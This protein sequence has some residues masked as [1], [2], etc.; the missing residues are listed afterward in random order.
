METLLDER[1]Q[2][3]DKLC[4]IVTVKQ[5]DVV[6][7]SENFGQETVEELAKTDDDIKQVMTKVDGLAASHMKSEQEFLSK[8]LQ[9]T[10]QKMDKQSSTLQKHLT[11]TLSVAQEQ[12]T[13]L[14]RQQSS[15]DSMIDAFKKHVSCWLLVSF[16]QLL[17]GNVQELIAIKDQKPKHCQNRMWN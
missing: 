15:M 4:N 2:T 9:G 17:G 8:M 16:F 1:G 5:N 7:M 10:K 3:Q 6:K 13:S 12:E 11:N 14:R